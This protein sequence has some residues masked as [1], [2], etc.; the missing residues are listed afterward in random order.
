M[1]D[2]KCVSQIFGICLVK[3]ATSGNTKVQLCRGITC[4]L[5]SKPEL[6]CLHGML[7]A[8]DHNELLLDPVSDM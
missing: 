3:R 2:W 8:M 5:I 7:L 6:E 1:I 4:R